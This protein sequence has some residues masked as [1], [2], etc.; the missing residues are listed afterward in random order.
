MMSRTI[1][2]VSL[3]A[4]L[5]GCAMGPNYERSNVPAPPQYR[6]ADAVSTVEPAADLSLHEKLNDP[7][8]TG[9]VETALEQNFDLR[10][11]AERVQQARA[12][13][14]IS[15]AALYPEIN[16]TAQ[17]VSNRTSSIGQAV[18]VPRGTNL[19]VAYTQVGLGLSWEL[20]V[21]GRIR[22]LKEAAL[23]EYLATEEARHG[24]QTSLVAEVTRA[25]FLLRAADLELEIAHKTQEI[26]KDGLR[27]TQL[28][29]DAGA[30]TGLDVSQAEQLLRTANAQIAASER[31]VGLAENEISLL[32]GHAPESIPRG[33]PLE[34]LTGPAEVPAGLPSSLLEQR[35]DIRQA[36]QTL[37]A[38]NARIGAAKAQ[39][40]P[41]ISLT[42]LLGAQSRYLTELFTGP[43]RHWNF[44]PTA[45]AP[46][47]NAGR[48][49]AG[50]K[51]SEAAQ[52]EALIQY[53]KA[54]Q[55]A[56]REVSDSL[57]TLSKT[58]E[59]RE[60]QQLLVAALE[61]STRLSNLRYR[62]GLDSY[63]Q[64]LDAQRN[65]FQSE[66]TLTQ[67]RYEELN[68]AVQLYRAL[69]VGWQ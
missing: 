23:A 55:T 62:G 13:Y 33:K 2:L 10:A 5:L 52:R 57:I 51:F 56:F 15:G 27:L 9:L 64:V 16:A 3:L 66:I 8:L 11:A 42:G 48:V 36:E 29:H 31:A 63:L 60:E 50:V 19:D 69:G 46:I 18:F 24:V 26:A 61:E 37:V 59:Q 6:G 12:Q 41:Q 4:A 40:F 30:A 22:R 34:E 68:A 49:R 44:T 32:L 25:Y 7:V 65:L 28:R 43:G 67:L 54:I 39:Y 58:R 38:A 1:L 14:G 47:F 21:W 17:H 35:P 45:T 20:D 53:E